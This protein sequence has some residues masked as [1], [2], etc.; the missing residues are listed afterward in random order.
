MTQ[1]SNDVR[2]NAVFVLLFV[3]SNISRTDSRISADFELAVDKGTG[4]FSS[5]NTTE[6]LSYVVLMFLKTNKEKIGHAKSDFEGEGA[7]VSYN[8]KL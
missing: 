1:K 6:L 7:M 2:N 5:C 4:F 8:L 3:T